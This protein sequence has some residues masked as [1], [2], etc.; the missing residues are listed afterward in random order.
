MDYDGLTGPDLNHDLDLQLL[1][2]FESTVIVKHILPKFKHNSI[3][4]N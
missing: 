3:A 1:D 2:N 4:N